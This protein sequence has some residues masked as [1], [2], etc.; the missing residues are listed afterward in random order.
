MSK[1]C[2]DLHTEGAFNPLNLLFR[3][4]SKLYDDL[5]T[6][7]TFNPFYKDIDPNYVTICIPKVHSTDLIL[8]I[9]PNYVTT[10]I[11]KVHTTILSGLS[12]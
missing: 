2:D 12:H 10:C 5:H 6:E 3:Y 8:D 9:D 7:G 1:L 11:P 4:R